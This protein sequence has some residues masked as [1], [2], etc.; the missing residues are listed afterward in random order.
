MKKQ[1][2]E[3]PAGPELYVLWVPAKERA[4]RIEGALRMMTERDAEAINRNLGVGTK[5][6]FGVAWLPARKVM[7]RDAEISVTVDA[8]TMAVID[9]SDCCLK[10]I[11]NKIAR[12]F[13]HGGQQFIALGTYSDGSRRAFPIV[14]REHYR[15]D[16]FGYHQIG[17]FDG[18]KRRLHMWDGLQVTWGG[19]QYVITGPKARVTL[20]RHEPV[21]DAGDAPPVEEV[22][23]PAR[24]AK[25]EPGSAPK[26]AHAPGKRKEPAKREASPK[27]ARKGAKA[28]SGTKTRA[29][30]AAR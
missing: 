18:D 30:R 14:P 12:P 29:A 4:A 1:T 28:L 11:E 24:G 3:M 6:A 13:L 21:A 22:D 20:R 2:K 8:E 27:G 19:E 23:G 26:T 9:A 10:I 5:D 17:D 7:G 16:T 15:L 25:R